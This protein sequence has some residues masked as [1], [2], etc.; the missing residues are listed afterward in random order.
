MQ[1]MEI[2]VLSTHLPHELTMLHYALEQVN[3][4][5]VDSSSNDK[6]PRL[7]M[8]FECFWLHA[9]NLFEFFKTDDPKASTISPHVFTK[10]KLDYEFGSSDLMERI[11]AQITHLQRS[12]GLSASAPLTGAEMIQVKERIDIAVS[13]FQAE[14]K[15]DLKEWWS[16]REPVAIEYAENLSPTACT[17]IQMTHLETS[18]SKSSIFHYDTGPNVTVTFDER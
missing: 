14:L 18:R 1:D 8:A 12:R 10:T 3:G 16:Q 17:E 15:D 11:N 6:D 5:C 4:L 9:R 13:R 2:E 7:I